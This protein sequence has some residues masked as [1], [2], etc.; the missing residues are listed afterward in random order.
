LRLK[1]LE[2][3][4]V[5][6]ESSFIAPNAVIIGDVEIGPESSIW[7]GCVLRGDVNYIKIGAGVNLQDN[8]IC[9]GQLGEFPVIIEDQV[10][11]G[12]GAVIHGC[13]I[14]R[15]ALIGIRA[16]LLNGSEIGEEAIVA[17]GSLVPPGFKV[18]ARTL[19]AG[20]PAR[21]KRELDERDFMLL[22]YTYTHYIEY[23]KE[24]IRLGIGL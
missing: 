7:Y 17:A 6:H 8:T 1:H 3:K 11:A 4:P 20:V 22:E 18:P 12:H 10:S 14:R 2:K 16:T 19:V 15:K 13:T 21:I 24:Y 5:I 23:S 9:H